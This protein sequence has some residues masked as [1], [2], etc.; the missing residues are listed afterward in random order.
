MLSGWCLGLGK[1]SLW[2]DLFE[3]TFFLCFCN[4]KRQALTLAFCADAIEA[5]LRTVGWKAAVAEVSQTSSDASAIS[6]LSAND[7]YRLSKIA[8]QAQLGIPPASSDLGYYG[9]KNQLDYRGA[10]LFPS[11]RLSLYERVDRRCEKMVADGFLEEVARLLHLHGDKPMTIPVVGYRQAI[12]F[13]TETNDPTI[14]DFRQFLG[15]F[16]VRNTAIFPSFFLISL[17][18]YRQRHVNMPR[19]K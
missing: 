8:A 12:T 1:L 13:L 3:V 7:F 6:R 18:W 16:A 9:P 5:R 15:K 11:D 10:F 17:W 19:G 4:E 2:I 14:E